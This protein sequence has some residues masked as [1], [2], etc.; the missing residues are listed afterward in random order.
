MSLL[1]DYQPQAEFA[2][3]HNVAERTV[4]RYRNLPNG[5]PWMYFG[6]KVYIHIPGAKEWLQRRVRINRTRGRD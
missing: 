1:D 3:E 6:G 5:L 4:N 2:K